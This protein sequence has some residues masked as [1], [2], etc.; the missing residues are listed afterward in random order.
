MLIQTDDVYATAETMLRERLLARPGARGQGKSRQFIDRTV[1]LGVWFLRKH[2]PYGARIFAAC[3]MALAKLLGLKDCAIRT[4]IKALEEIGL[5]RH[6]PRANGHQ[7]K[8]RS[9]EYAAFQFEIGSIFALL[10]PAAESAA[11]PVTRQKPGE[12]STLEIKVPPGSGALQ[13]P[14]RTWYPGAPEMKLARPARP[15]NPGSAR[16][17]AAR[18]AGRDA[19]RAWAAGHGIGP[20][21]FDAIP[22]A[23]SAPAA[24]RRGELALAAL[25]AQRAP[26]SLPHLSTSAAAIT[27]RTWRLW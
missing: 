17:K 4:S 20:D 25:M 11:Q 13:V 15:P 8:Y 27:R 10:F 22:D 12:G 14:A 1:A 5:L 7:R 6:L 9:P 16:F 24:R 26:E 19:A 3:R 21:I 18:N 23:D 2:G